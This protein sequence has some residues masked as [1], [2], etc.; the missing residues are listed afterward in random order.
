MLFGIA[1]HG[2]TQKNSRPNRPVA[3]QSKLL[4]PANAHRARTRAAHIPE[5]WRP[6]D[7]RP[8]HSLCLVSDDDRNAHVACRDPL[9]EAKIITKT[10]SALFVEFEYE[11]GSNDSRVIGPRSGASLDVTFGCVVGE[12]TIT[13]LNPELLT[14]EIWRPNPES[15]APANPPTTTR[16]RNG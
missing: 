15:G 9:A 14:R 4:I 2:I 7:Q 1:K 6:H 8:T 11:D 12:P 3:A 5:E 13:P 10:D 16:R